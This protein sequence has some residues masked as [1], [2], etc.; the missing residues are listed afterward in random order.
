MYNNKTEEKFSFVSSIKSK[1]FLGIS[2]YKIL[3][4]FWIIFITISTS[5]RIF[6][7]L[8]FLKNI[9]SDFF[10]GLLYG[11]RM[12]TIYFSFFS[13]IFVLLYSLNFIKTS[14][15][16]YSA[17]FI[18]YILLEL[19]TIVFMQNFLAR[20]NSLVLEHLSNFKELFFMVWGL[21]SYYIVFSI[22]PLLYLTKKIYH[23]FT[24]NIK[25]GD[26]VA[27]LTLLPL[28]LALL[29][30]GVR[31]SVGM[32]TPNPS[33]YTFSKNDLNNELANNTLISI[34]YSY[35]ASKKEKFYNY[36]K[37]SQKEAVVNVKRLNHIDNNSQT[38]ERFQK[39]S[40][41]HEKNIILV[42]LESFG[43]EHIGYLGGT[44]T[45]PVLDAL[46][47]ESLYFTNLYAVGTRTSWGVSSVTTSLYPLPS[48][49]YVKA[50]KSQKNFYT[51]AKTLK[52]HHYK[53]IFLYSGD[54]N[55]DNMSGFLFS[56]GYDKIYSKED[57]DS[58]KKR[59]TWGY[60]DEDLYDKAIE[61]I[62]EQ[63]NK[64]YFLTLLS[65]SSHEPFDYPKGKVKPYKDAPL[66]GFSN[67]IKY[68]DYAIGTFIKKLK[69]NG[70]L[71]D[72]VIAFVADH[73]SKAYSSTGVPIEKYK[74]ASMILST[75]FKGGKEYS[76][77]ASQIDIAPTILDV[78]GISDS[79]PTM[80]SSVLQ[81]QRDS[82]LLLANKRNFAYLTDTSYI[83]YRDKQKAKE[84]NYENK[85]IE[86]NQTKV[87]DGLSYIYTSK[88]LY[89]NNLYN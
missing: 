87:K 12:D 22:V 81:N 70:M 73:C 65:L 47:K 61:V 44:K 20:P 59:Y 28:I 6:L 30:L 89:D 7:S 62:K 64:P 85:Q 82:A 13:I 29:F 45:T 67:G 52:K 14:R 37:L 40:F 33:F 25:E 5:F 55:F 74:I 76:K 54:T 19:S 4:K 88:Y 3:L 58:S 86:T 53:N 60:C 41:K 71:K 31:S 68:A 32:S 42:I 83:L 46:T 48:V 36:G 10:I 16:F 63:K 50:I 38:L 1:L 17:I 57:F 75:D 35:Y 18:L 78:A 24:N 66:K 43:H 23:Y 8:L 21:Y 69:K 15:I 49:E 77:I 34:I 27:K 2:Q 11:I 72:T 80:G 51:I 39:S 9:N 56:N 84:F 26:I 79:I